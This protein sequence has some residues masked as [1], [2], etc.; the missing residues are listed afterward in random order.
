MYLGLWNDMEVDISQRKDLS[1]LP[2][3]A[4]LKMS[5]GATRLEEGKI[6]E[7]KCA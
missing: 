6:V 2:W 4:Y 3:Q 1:S 5:A 7:I